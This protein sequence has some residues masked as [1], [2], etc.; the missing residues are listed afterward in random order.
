MKENNKKLYKSTKNKML[1]GVCAGI[2][3]HFEID[4]RVIRI[5]W[6]LSIWFFGTGIFVYIVAA[7][8]MPDKPEEE[9]VEVKE[10]VETKTEEVVD[11]KK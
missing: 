6:F 7:L 8:I 3:E 5:A 4:V 9:K 10:A 11:I 1:F 2:A